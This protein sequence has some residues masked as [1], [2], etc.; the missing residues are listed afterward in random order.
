MPFNVPNEFVPQSGQTIGSAQVDQNFDSIEARIDSIEASLGQTSGTVNEVRKIL[1]TQRPSYIGAGDPASNELI[2]RKWLD[3]TRGYRVGDVLLSIDPNTPDSNYGVVWAKM[4]GQ[5][6]SQSTYPDFYT[7]CQT[8]GGSDTGRYNPGAGAT[9]GNFVAPDWRGRIPA[10]VL[11]AGSALP[12]TVPNVVAANWLGSSV[13]ESTHA[14]T[15]AE[16]PRHSHKYSY[17][18]GAGTGSSR[19]APR[20]PDDPESGTGPL[21]GDVLNTGSGTAF[22]VVQQVFMTLIW[23]RVK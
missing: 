23:V 21:F 12:A 3:A 6:L 2:D 1:Y 9:A 14:Q 20:G 7:I 16:M 15:E 18:L 13:G 17:Y 5:Q 11:G 22:N 8:I 19:Q 4:E 10:H